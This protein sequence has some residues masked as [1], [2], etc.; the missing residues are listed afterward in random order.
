MLI[1]EN[2]ID[3]NLEA[4]T[5]EDVITKLAE[6]AYKEGRI[7][8]VD[9]Y[10]Q[11]VLKREEEYSTSVGFGVAIPHGKTDAVNEPFLGF[12]KT[13]DVEW[14]APDGKPVDLVFIIGVP[15]AQAGDEHLRI[16][17]KLSRKL[18]KEEFR[19]LLRKANSKEDILAAVQEAVN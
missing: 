3:M 1:N 12:A 16:L 14:A 9:A 6:M 4:E 8:D 11:A 7:N 18:M 5:K 2:L 10:V 17:A 15:E 13:K 19:Q